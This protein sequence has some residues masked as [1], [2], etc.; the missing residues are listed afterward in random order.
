MSRL[1]TMMIVGLVGLAVFSG[2]GEALPTMS[3][4]G[5]VSYRGEPLDHGSLRFFGADGRPIGCVIQENGS[6][7]IDLLPGEY[8]VSVSS[9]PK[10]PSDHPEG[11][12]P[13]RDSRALP[14]R[15]TQP[16]S[17]GLSAIVGA[18]SPEQTYDIALE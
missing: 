17:S 7:E 15:Y 16:N 3:L 2:C 11:A 10:L 6:Y 13:P 9:P 12:P 18:E 4:S 14:A 8:Q 1:A 5:T